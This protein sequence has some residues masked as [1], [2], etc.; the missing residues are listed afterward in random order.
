MSENKR[1]KVKAE[2]I[3]TD[4]EIE[5]PDHDS[6]K[7]KLENKLR[8]EGYEVKIDYIRT[9]LIKEP[10]KD[11]YELDFEDLDYPFP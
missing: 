2:V 6:V 7:R 8:D 11:D 9:D 1:Y 4:F 10:P 5:A 3:L